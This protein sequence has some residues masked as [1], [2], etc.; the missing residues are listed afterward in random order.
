[1]EH[2]KAAKNIIRT[3][4]VLALIFIL[5][6]I[7]LSIYVAVRYATL[8]YP[9]SLTDRSKNKIIQLTE[10]DRQRITDTFRIELPENQDII[11]RGFGKGEIPDPHGWVCYYVEF[12]GVID[13]DELM[14]LNEDIINEFAHETTQYVKF[15]YMTEWEKYF[16]EFIVYVY[17]EETEI[18]Q[19]RSNVAELYYELFEKYKN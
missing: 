8:T 18:D 2:K 14:Q 11:I 16:P 5:L 6:A 4:L 7:T 17:N 3:I 15:G 13:L 9:R 12:E 1:M 19:Y 10:E